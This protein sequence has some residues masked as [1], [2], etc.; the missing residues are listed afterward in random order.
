M[1]CFGRYALVF[2]SVV[3]GALVSAPMT[4]ADSPV[5]FQCHWDATCPEVMIAG[6]P[7]ATLGGGP[8]PF[9]GYGD[10]SLERDPVTGTLWMSYSWLDVLVT[11]FSPPPV[12]D[13][14]VRTHIARS[15]DNGATFTYVGAANAPTSINHPD[16]N[17]PGWTQQEVSTLLREP[18]GGWQLLWLTYFDPQGTP[19][20]GAPDGHSDPYFMRSLAA[21]PGDLGDVS[22]AWA[23]G[24]GT[25]ASFGAQYNLSVLPQLSD[26]V[27]LTEPALFA[28]AGVTYLATN[29]VVVDGSGRRDDL[30]RLV[31]LRQEASGY[32]Y[33][34]TLLTYD[35][36]VDLGA[37]R[38]EQAD[39]L[40][41]QSGAVIL[42]ATPI[43]NSPAPNHLGCVAFEVTDIASAQVRRDAGGDAVQLSRITGDDNGIGAGL[44]TYDAASSTGVLMVMHDQPTPNEVEFSMR[45]TGIHPE[46]AAPPAVGGAALAPDLPATAGEGDGARR[47]WFVAA[48]AA[49]LCAAIG[50][51]FVRCRRSVFP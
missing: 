22:Q 35:D 44:C 11:S 23:R 5:T 4:S 17:A 21:A 30:E 10:P 47:W 14:G 38:I 26:C 25:S 33:V 3:A 16:S 43:R 46:V 8:A 24:S 9:R 32:S 13:F 42:I 19:A 45:A 28:K 15:D 31:L 7:Y 20:P 2:V 6:D 50:V 39:L 18:A 36:A 1:R 12:F 34:G 41:S 40:F 49:V 37:S 48:A 51:G 29:C 27:A